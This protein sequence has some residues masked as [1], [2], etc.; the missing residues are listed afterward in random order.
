MVQVLNKV[1]EDKDL[2]KNV[3]NTKW[4]PLKTKNLLLN[5]V[6]YINDPVMR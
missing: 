3:T 4:S 6:L 1:V 5:K 2:E